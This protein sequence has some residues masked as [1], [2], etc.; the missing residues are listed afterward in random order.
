MPRIGFLL[1]V[2]KDRLAEYKERHRAVWPEMLAADPMRAP[3]GSKKFS[4]WS[5]VGIAHPAC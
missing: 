2:R 3:C 5:R 1:K 4:I